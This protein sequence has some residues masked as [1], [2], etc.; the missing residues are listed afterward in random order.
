MIQRFLSNRY[1]QMLLLFVLLLVAVAQSFS[2]AD[3]RERLRSLTFDTY[4]Q[5]K[6]REASDQVVIVDIDEASLE[7]VGQMPWPR[8]VMGQ[9]VTNL[10]EMGAAVVVFDMV[11][12]EP[13][14]SSPMAL[15]QQ[16]S[17]EAGYQDI[18]AR[19]S[20]LPD[21]DVQFGL[22]IRTAGN[23][24]TG[25][26]FTNDATD[27]TPRQKGIFRGKGLENFVPILRGASVN[28][29]AIT[30]HSAG[31]GS[32]FVTTGADGII[33]KVPMLVGHK[34]Q[35]SEIVSVYPSLSL[36]ALRVYHKERGGIITLSDEK[37]AELDPE[38]FGIQDITLGREGIKIPTTGRGEFLVYFAKSAREWYIPAKDVLDRT[39]NP[40][41]VAG[42]IVFVGTSAVGLKDIRSTPLDAF[43]P[44]VEVHL[45]IVDQVLQSQ[46]L[47]RSIEAEGLEAF[48]ILLIGAGVIL[49][50]PFLGALSQLI[51]FI[52]VI[53]AVLA[54]GWFAFDQYGLLI[55]VL[56]PVLT[57][58]LVFMLATILTYLR[59]EQEKKQVRDAFGLYIS[60]EFI[61]ELT[62][63]PER[64]SLGGE[65]RP[66]SVLFSDVRG[67]TSISEGLRPQELIQL[68]NDFLT[69]MSDVIMR[70]RGTIDKYMGDAIMAFWNAPL[71]DEAHARNACLSA[72]QMCEALKVLNE[73]RVKKL[74][75]DVKKLQ[76]GIGINTG[77]CAV[78]NMGSRQRF[79]Y[80]A[81][82]DAVNLASRLE[83][84]TKT[85]GVEVLI[86]ETTAEDV[87]DMAL[88]CL[89]KL[90]VKG[91]SEPVEIY[92][93]LGDGKLAGDESFRKQK[94]LHDEMR[95][96]YYACDF[97][98]ALKVIDELMQVDRFDLKVTY[99]LFRERATLYLQ[100]PPPKDW[101]GVYVAT[102]K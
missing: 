12:S 68:M 65:T 69:P 48:L 66:L 45:N 36:E 88:L 94:A 99:E 82:G 85:Y 47:T 101:D 67:F 19:L 54:G 38:R 58:V 28:L 33:R 23:V 46:F 102:S 73:E 6:P 24:V 95:Q 41:A 84:Q 52:T 87:G 34:K 93:L 43:I 18:V 14:R 90:Q 57:L 62:E 98:G 63:N 9:L 10:K 51:F 79:A 16:L 64:L 21:P 75:D 70:N 49:T 26:S 83:G 100:L 29:R 4:N 56:Y 2:H 40:E 97:K 30:K 27:K 20:G 11:F 53:M 91:R 8:S 7:V 50:A 81:L 74:G 17:D 44:G 22:D 55:D 60:P 71:D 61:K 35:G 25:F 5:I 77:L 96:A 37:Y 80:S 42:K 15:A 13:D 39:L 32:F 3:W 86:S 1:L 89:D 59:A 31:N 92:T 76:A 72:L 78:G